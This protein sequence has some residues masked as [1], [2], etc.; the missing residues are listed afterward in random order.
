MWPTLDKTDCGIRIDLEGSELGDRIDQ[1]NQ[2][3]YVGRDPNKRYDVCRSLGR[4]PPCRE[5]A[6]SQRAPYNKAPNA[7]FGFLRYYGFGPILWTKLS[8]KPAFCSLW[9]TGMLRVVRTRLVK[10]RRTQNLSCVS[11]LD[12]NVLSLRTCPPFDRHVKYRH[13]DPH[14]AL[15]IGI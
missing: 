3:R 7:I 14:P 13:R 4:D 6:A 2:H 5:C 10:S 12:K 1:I 11:G 15:I 9:P 8:T